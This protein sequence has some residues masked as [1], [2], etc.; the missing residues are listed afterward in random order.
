MA[1]PWGSLAEE[2]ARASTSDLG[3][4]DF[5]YDPVIIKKGNSQRE[6]SDGLLIV[7]DRGV[8]LQVKARKP[9]KGDGPEKARTWVEKNVDKATKQV[10][11]TR[12]TISTQDIRFRSRRGRDLLL[13]GQ[14]DWP[15][16]ILLDIPVDH[17][18][19]QVQSDDPKT[20]VMA[21]SDW[22]ALNQMIRSTSG[23]I[24][25]VERVVEANLG[26]VDLGDEESRY[27]TFAQL[28]SQSVAQEG[29]D[30]YLRLRTLTRHEE[31]ALASLDE[32]IDSDIASADNPFTANPGSVADRQRRAIEVID[33]IP[34]LTRARVGGA[35]LE[36]VK[37]STNE[38]RPFAGTAA[39]IPNSVNSLPADRLLFFFDV[40]QN[41]RDPRDF[42]ANAFDYAA[43]R[44]EEAQ[45]QGAGGATLLLAR[46]RTKTGEV[47][48]TFV[49]IEGD[50]DD[51]NIPTEVRW[52]I[53]DEYGIVTANGPKRAI[54]TGRNNLCPCQSGKKF[55]RCHGY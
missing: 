20:L 4:P 26:E 34:V 7:R 42:E 43:V 50:S 45:A 44:H 17:R 36:R 1:T 14:N 22:H 10:Q 2:T 12:K 5:V 6:V 35:L 15:A 41:W 24:G 47:G 52:S 3:V 18:G 16:V 46:L 55:K 27:R 48:R 21:L 49:L 37:R 38:L 51:L 8:I 30:P 25:Y 9:G 33:T 53:L 54:D 29:G 32:W 31:L 11:G 39:F 19:I 28:D 40:G 23:V 13:S